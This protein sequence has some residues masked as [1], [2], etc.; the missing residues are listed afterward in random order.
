MPTL[1]R[2][3][4]GTWF[5]PMLQDVFRNFAELPRGIKR[6]IIATL[7]IIDAT[8]LGL[9]NQQGILNQVDKLFSDSLPD[10]LIW[11]LQIVQSLCA[12]FFYVKILFDDLNS[13]KYRTIAIILSPL[14]LIILTFVTIDFLLS[15]LDKGASVT[16]DPVALGTNTLIWSSTYL[17]IAIG[18]T[19]TYKV[20]RYG[21][22]AQSE[23]FMI[24]MFMGMIFAWS[25]HYY[26]LYDA[27]ADGV[28]AWSLLFRAILAGLVIT[29][30]VGVLID[31]L[32]YRGFRIRRANPQVMMIASLG[33]ALILRSIYF[34]RFGASKVVFSADA[35]LRASGNRWE[36]PTTKL[37]L[38][39]GDNSL[40]TAEPF[41]DLNG[42]GIWQDT[43]TYTDLDGDGRYDTAQTYRHFN[44]EQTGI[45]ET[46]GEPIYSRIVS[47][48]TKPSYEIYNKATDCISEITT[49]Y[50]YYKGIVPAVVFIS[51]GLLMLLIN[52]TR[53][54]RK[55]RAVADNP[56]LAASSGINVERIQVTSAF[57][58]A[59]ITGL[60]GAIFA[61]T[62]LFNPSTAFTLLLPSFAVIVLG[63][64]GSL[65]GAVVACV[66]IAFVRAL[67][68]PILIGVGFRL[69]RSNYAT[70][71]GVMPYIFLVAILL[72]IPSG[73]GDYWEKW[74]IDRIR[75]K[76]ENP[77]QPSKK[78]LATL[79]FLPTG[80][81][82]I[83][84]W[85]NGR[86]DKAQN[87][88]MAAIGSY[89]IHRFFGFIEKNSL[90][91]GSCNQVCEDYGDRIDAPN[92]LALITNSN[93]GTITIEDSPFT[94]SDLGQPPDNLTSSV[95]EWTQ[96]SLSEL[97]Q[98]WFDLMQSEI[99]FVNLIAD[100]GEIIWPLTPLIL[101]FLAISEGFNILSDGRVDEYRTRIGIKLSPFF[102]LMDS[103]RNKIVT[104]FHN[105]IK[106]ISL[107]LA[108]INNTHRDAVN[109][110]KVHIRNIREKIQDNMFSNLSENFSI[111]NKY[112]NLGD[113]GR[114]G[115]KGSWISFILSLS[116][117][118]MF[119]W[120]LPISDSVSYNWSKIFQVS[121]VSISLA[122]FILMA[123]SLNLH[124]GYTGMV[125]FGVIF[126]VGVGAVTVAL[127]TA[128]EEMHGYGWDILPAAIVA[129]LIS[130]F[131]GW[132]LAYPTARLRTDYFA[133]VTISLGEI[134]RVLLSGEPLLRTGPILSSIG[135]G[136]YPLPLK[137]WWFCGPGIV[138]G[139]ESEFTSPDNCRSAVPELTTPASTISDLLNLG[140]PAPYSLLLAILGLILVILVWIIL[141]K[142][143]NSPWGRILKS[144]REDEDV[145]QH[146]GHD[147]L[148]H[149][150]YSLALGAAIA[151]L[152]GV[153]WAWKLTGFGPT[154]MAP[155]KSTFLVWAAFIIGGAANN[156]GM[157]IGASIIVLME[158]VFNVLVAAS[159][160]DL[161][162][163]STAENIDNLFIWL[164]S[165][166]WEVT[167]VF[168][169][170]AVFGLFTKYQTIFELGFWGA[171]TF[172]F[173]A[174]MMDGTRSL[175]PA[176]NIFG[177]VSIAGANM[178]YVKLLL[179][180]ALMLFSL[181][182]NPMGILP[183]VPS[184]PV[185][186]QK[187]GIQ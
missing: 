164:V 153:L 78:S 45:D 166:Q 181:K 22:F 129:I 40:R 173:T 99:N 151:S 102:R 135:L 144:I 124:T 26:P 54:G 72:I 115:R 125:N 93:E 146:H 59:G 169:L 36:I 37:R 7:L 1:M 15:G 21:N 90:A 116:I 13:S 155:A 139:P 150:A 112:L 180:G 157:I 118:I 73:L 67:S 48:G 46:T 8:V 103:I 84:H 43:E 23:F 143:M 35:D 117:I 86:S 187:E 66:L 3:S 20:Q 38:N 65:S 80:I 162:L 41:V 44:C 160:P 140:E 29:G 110:A 77:Q 172:L 58:S 107:Y 111:R 69:S 145:A 31:R 33:I 161:P 39:L 105:F 123:F 56:D 70:L 113:Y 128:P 178:A 55:M 88:T 17:S 89:F 24:G 30:L 18:L 49:N 19:L 120:W 121:N 81:L 171:L 87:F 97:N 119:I 53:L 174:I 165:E 9:L 85:R 122:I 104:I 60:G 74:K 149:K 167:T 57:L 64:I 25:E 134:L 127:L 100:I 91:D 96:N 14:F 183:E 63:S 156:R 82:G 92:N 184:R 101:W 68:S 34:M 170:V 152:A 12:G 137:E 42:D 130:A 47:E 168:I 159:T 27:P 138:T 133:I 16:L 163:Y 95:S 177:V 94:A 6:T 182:F 79:A 2:I 185:R 131:F 11:L 98:K 186:P 52:K 62:L 136:N 175:E 75:N 83:H 158:F 179:I 71:E 76:N 5:R 176:T 154:F 32:V 10:D 142:M 126:F 50:P 108:K 114:Q 132:A 148:T 109:V 28:I 61:V 106:T 141:D 147:V 51:I 4:R